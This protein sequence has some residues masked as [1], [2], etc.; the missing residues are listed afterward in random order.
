MIYLDSSALVKLVFEEPESNALAA[1]LSDRGSE[2]RTSSALA[3]VEVLRTCRQIDPVAMWLAE[4]IIGGL[5]LVPL[6][7]EVIDAAGILEPTALRSLDALHLAAA[8]SVA[9]ALSAFVSY[10]A[11]LNEAAGAVGLPVASPS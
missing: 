3:S 4:R 10:D 8:S 1:W 5:D 11:R 9:P 2:S 7:A 6:D